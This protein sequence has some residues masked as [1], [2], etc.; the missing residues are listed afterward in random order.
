MSQ[1]KNLEIFIK[2][3][4]F[5]IFKDVNPNASKSIIEK[6][7][8]RNRLT[9]AF[10]ST[11]GEFIIANKS[12]LADYLINQN[13]EGLL[14]NSNKQL[15]HQFS[16]TVS[17]SLKIFGISDNNLLTKLSNGQTIIHQI[18]QKRKIKALLRLITKED[19]KQE[20]ETFLQTQKPKI[21]KSVAE[22]INQQD[23]K[24]INHL[25]KQNHDFTYQNTSLGLTIQ[26]MEGI[27]AVTNRTQK[28]LTASQHSNRIKP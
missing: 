17:H 15:N 8:V 26:F 3:Y 11:F 10:D 27:L 6:N 28:R 18:G 13:K 25:V 23:W 22:Q 19:G 21:N 5:E 7:I 20:L 16:P 14:Q 4:G 9:R 24:K 2:T 12:E 1:S